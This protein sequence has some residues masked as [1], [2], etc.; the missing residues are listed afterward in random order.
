MKEI[1][2][3]IDEQGNVTMDGK[4]FEGTECDA[5]M[6]DMEKSIGEVTKR[7]NKPEYHRKTA[8]TR[9]AGA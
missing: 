5:F 8:V 7:V 6:A 2:V 9:K 4:G 3:D 1:I